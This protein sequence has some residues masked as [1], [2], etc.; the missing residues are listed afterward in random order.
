M[1]RIL[2]QITA[3]VL[4]TLAYD[5][6]FA[7]PVKYYPACGFTG[8]M[9]WAVYM[10]LWKIHFFRSEQLCVFLATIVVVVLS[11][12]FAVIKKST[13]TIFLISGILP[14]VPG[15]GI[16]WTA[17][18]LVSGNSHMAILRGTNAL[19]WVFAIVLAIVLVFELPQKLFKKILR[20]PL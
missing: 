17:F 6:M 11:R 19:E 14:L 5:V 16:Y 4:G 1:I 18:Y 9:G 20:Q 13:V 12:Y 8:G 3:A 10:I 2:I 15:A 7:V